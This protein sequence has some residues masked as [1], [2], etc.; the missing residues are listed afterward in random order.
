[1]RT[2]LLYIIG[3]SAALLSSCH[4]DFSADAYLN[5]SE[6][7]PLTACALI[8]G[9][10]GVRS[11]AVDKG[12]ETSDKLVAYL[13]HVTWDGTTAGARTSV[14]ADKAPQLVTFTKGS[15]AMTAYDGS[16]ITPIGTG[17]ALGLT[18]T[19]TK[20][21]ADLTASPL[22]Y[23][24]DFSSSADADHDLRTDGH[25]LQSFYG[26]CY[27][28]GTPT[29]ALTETT[30]ALGWT[31]SADQHEGFKTSDLLWSAEQTPVAYAHATYN[32][33]TAHGQLILPY[34]HAM[35]K[36]TVE[37]VCEDGFDANVANFANASVVLKGMQTVA[38]LIA[39]TGTS[40]AV[41]G[42]ADANVK[43]ITTQPIAHAT[44]SNVCYSF[45][46]L[47]A[48]TTFIDGKVFAAINNVDGNN[49]TLALSDAILNTEAANDWASRLTGYSA[50]AGG[51]T[52][53]GVN[54]LITITIKK[55]TISV[56]AEIR[57]WDEVSATGV[58]VIQF[59]SD[60]TEKTGAIATE[61]QTDGFDLYKAPEAATPAYGKAATTYSYVD[62]DAD[63]APDTWKRT[64][65]IY[66]P[67]AT[68]RFFFRALSGATADD[69]DSPTNESL[70]MENGHDVLWGTTK[71]HKG[72]ALD[73]SSY[74]YAK[75]AALNP[76][77][78]DV[79]LTFSH[80]MAKVTF[81]LLDKNLD[82]TLPDGVSATDYDNPLNPRINL[83]GAT[84]QIVDLATGGTLNLHD[85]S[86]TPAEHTSGN[87][88][89]SEDT[90]SDP[91]RMGYYAAFENG[92]ATSYDTEL[93]LCDYSVIPQTI[94]DGAMVIVTL[95]DGTTYKTQ[96]NTCTVTA[97]ASGTAIMHPVDAVINQWNRGVSYTYTILLSKEKITFR[98]LIENWDKVEGGGKATLEW[99]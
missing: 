52:Q 54:Y 74:D 36:V 40:T 66:W 39:P 24:D 60:V 93:T 95:A 27:N 21:T 45:A 34:T 64:N 85:G 82:A 16:D 11:R 50:A 94:G 58:G 12:F 80:P 96:L 44:Q 29:T 75:G 13:R 71:E 20:Q 55:Q 84:I 56:N 18:S 51:T 79:P 92:S 81:K 91:K 73:G 48:P 47:I 89:F 88:L 35:S 49:Y 28:G 32:G 2:H 90:A 42:T 33:G 87:K 30:G 70:T 19:N 63:D 9:A 76:R 59:A 78:G 15:T 1:M 62:T 97:T 38:S 46:A 6:K 72:T 57:D 98:A 3:V 99:D 7:T 86:I 14:A 77:T 65:E 10:G 41:P 31:V 4:D 83:A 17:V 53:P 22:L 43:N 61:L 26:Y 8:D 25:Y 37:V 69:H 23:W 68:D 5:G 67:N